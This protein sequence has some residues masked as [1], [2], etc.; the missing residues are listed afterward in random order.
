MSAAVGEGT[1]SVGLTTA[2]LS[3]VL[4]DLQRVVTALSPEQYATRPGGFPSSVGAQVRH[5]LDH[6]RAFL[7]GV[8]AGRIDYESRLRGTPIETDR[9]A[10]LAALGALVA[11][12]ECPPAADPGEAIRVI[13]RLAPSQP[14][15][16]ML[17]TI[18]RELAFVTSHTTHHNALIG[19]L[20]VALG[21]TTPRRFG[22]AASTLAF[23]EPL[24]CA[25]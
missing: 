22:F 6:V 10:A 5:C 8:A 11:R 2:P 3:E 19:A 4:R 14:S 15:V 9:D 18:G 21:V 13:D 1:M 25:R 24:T 23:L 17:S 7:D 16:V 12:L 20:A